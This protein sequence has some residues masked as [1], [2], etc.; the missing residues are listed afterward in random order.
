MG[1]ALILLVTQSKTILHLHDVLKDAGASTN[2]F[3]RRA[4]ERFIVKL[5]N[6][7]AFI[8][9]KNNF[10]FM[11]FIF[12]SSFI[13][14]VSVNAEGIVTIATLTGKCTKVEAM[15]VLADPKLC[16]NKLINNIH[17]NG[18]SAFTFMLKDDVLIYFSGDGSKQIHTDEDNA[19]QPIDRVSFTFDG[20][21]DELKAI[22][23]CVF[24]NPYKHKPAKVIC[25]A[26]T[27]QGTFSGEFIS[28][29]V[30]PDIN[31]I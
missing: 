23:F 12:T 31:E 27:S 9:M 10:L 5:A 6:N 2:A 11:V 7:G 22:G 24:S 30:S 19:T 13:N 28:N 29:G 8:K 25:S 4:L 21:T 3:Q 1:W 20:S 17:P 15:G 16:S 26:D 14:P 18:R